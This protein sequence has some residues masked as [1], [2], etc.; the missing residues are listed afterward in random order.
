L[1]TKP[2]SQAGNCAG[3][4]GQTGSIT[5]RLERNNEEVYIANVRQFYLKG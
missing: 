2:G 1:E 3:Y 5:L 4:G